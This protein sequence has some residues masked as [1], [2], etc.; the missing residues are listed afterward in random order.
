MYEIKVNLQSICPYI[1]NKPEE[2]K[3]E[4]QSDGSWRQINPPVKIGKGSV[5]PESVGHKDENGYFIP[6]KQI[7]AAMRERS[8]GIKLGKGKMT[9]KNL[10]TSCIRVEPLR[11][12]LN[13]QKPDAIY[14]EPCFKKSGQ[15]GEMVFNPRPMFNEWSAEI[16]IIVLEDSIPNEAIM[17]CIVNAGLF[18]GIGSRHVEYGRFIVKGS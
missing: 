3:F 15:G 5:D 9:L 6:A 14:N 17:G 16:I 18:Q 13:K 11:I 4:I 7:W 2:R 12:Y 1:Q 8:G 10:F